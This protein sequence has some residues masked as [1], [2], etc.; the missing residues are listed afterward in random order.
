MRQQVEEAPDQQVSLTDPDARAMATSGKGTGIVG[1]NFQAVIDAE[2]HLIVAHAVTNIGNDRAQLVPMGLLAQEATGCATLTVLAD[3]G[4]LN[5]DQVLACEG[6]GLLPCVPKTLTSTHA[7]RGLTTRHHESGSTSR[8]ACR[9]TQ[10]R[11]WPANC[12]NDPLP[13]SPAGL[14]AV[15]RI[16]RLPPAPPVGRKTDQG[17][18]HR[19][20]PKT[21]CHA[22]RHAR[23]RYRLYPSRRDLIAVAGKPGAVQADHSPGA[24]AAAPARSSPPGSGVPDRC[25][26]SCEGI[27]DSASRQE[28]TRGTAKP[29]AHCVDAH[30]RTS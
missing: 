28:A 13:R 7:K 18:T 10:R 2:H 15:C 6:T 5:G 30:V 20:C 4:Y 22:E 17:G 24:A 19:Y 8:Q 23:Q 14:A 29:V 25:G 27:S 9:P 3:R 1:Y 16:P 26:S 21:T 12:P 11:R